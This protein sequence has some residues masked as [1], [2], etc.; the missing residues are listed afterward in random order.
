MYRRHIRARYRLIERRSRKFI[1]HNVLHADDP[2]H[3][4]AL[5]AAI[6]M[7]VAFSPTVGFQM[8]IVVFLAW[9]LRANKVIGLPIVWISNPA[10][11]VPIYYFCYVVGRSML[12]WQPVPEHWWSRLGQPPAGWWSAVTFYWTRLVEIAAPLWLG[13]TVIG[14]LL[15]YLSY[16][17]LY[18]LIRK[19]RLRRWGQLLPPFYER[20]RANKQRGKD[21]AAD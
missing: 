14:M 13:C 9:L 17:A 21:T 15:A 12:G 3:R 16:C 19:Y 5:G 18:Y 6:G 4:L 8:M 10:T 1:Y 11:I 20:S 2:P 7:F